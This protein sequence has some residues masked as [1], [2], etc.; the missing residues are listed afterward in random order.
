MCGSNTFSKAHV[1]ILKIEHAFKFH[2]LK[3]EEKLINHVSRIISAYYMNLYKQQKLLSVGETFH[4]LWPL[5]LNYGSKSN[6]SSQHICISA[7][8]KNQHM[9]FIIQCLSTI[10]EMIK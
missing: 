10:R 5:W 4:K 8:L 3:E 1:K 9:F 7:S 2:V 6:K